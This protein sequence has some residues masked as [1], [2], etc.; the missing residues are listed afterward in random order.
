MVVVGHQMALAAVLIYCGLE[1]A[2][3]RRG[4]FLETNA[5]W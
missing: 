3:K 1:T 5:R 2:G 4:T